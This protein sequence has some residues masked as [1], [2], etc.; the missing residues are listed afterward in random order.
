MLHHFTF[1]IFQGPAYHFYAGS[2]LYWYI[3]IGDSIGAFGCDPD[4]GFHLLFRDFQDGMRLAVNQESSLDFAG[5]H[6]IQSPVLAGVE[7]NQRV[8][9]RWYEAS[10][11]QLAQPL[12]DLL[13]LPPS[14]D[15]S[16]PADMLS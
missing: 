5:I 4:E 8:V 16:E 6:K 15:E 13:P 14:C 3:G 10:D 9:G 1:D 7:E 11:T 12:R 2:F